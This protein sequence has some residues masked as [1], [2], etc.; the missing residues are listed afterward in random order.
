M[1]RRAPH[2][3]DGTA[4][5]PGASGRATLLRVAAFGLAFGVLSSALNHV[6]GLVAVYAS[7]TVDTAWAW[8]FVAFLASVTGL[9]LAVGLFSLF[10][11]WSLLD[12]ANVISYLFP[13]MPV[14][15][16]Q[17]GIY[18]VYMLGSYGIGTMASAVFLR[19]TGRCS[20]V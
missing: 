5:R 4:P 12:G 19:L 15:R 10:G 11:F 14:R 13:D 20:Q 3:E 9:G 7:K 6:G 17:R 18:L 1:R 16:G 2:Q 8:L